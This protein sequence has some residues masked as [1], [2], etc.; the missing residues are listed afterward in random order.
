MLR[1]GVIGLGGIGRHHLTRYRQVP[2]ARVV[3]AADVR[4][5]A[6]Q[7]DRS[8]DGLFEVP[9]TEVRWF[10]DY[11]D[12]IASGSVDAVDICLPTDLHRPAAVAALEAGLHALVEKPMALIVADCDAMLAAV[13]RPGQVL[14]VAHC[15][16]FWPEYQYLVDLVRSGA[17]GRLLSLQL[18]RQGTRPGGINSG[19]MSQAARSGGAILDLHIHDVDFCQYLLGLPRGIY[20]QGGQS[21]G[22]QAGYDYVLASFDYGAGLQVSA[23]AHWVDV[24]L[25]FAARYEARL[26]KAFLRF[27]SSQEPSLTVYRDGGAEH[28]ELP[29]TDA[30]VNEIRYFCAQSLA[31]E[32]PHRCPAGEARNSVGL[33]A[34]ERA[35]IERGAPVSVAEVLG[36]A[37]G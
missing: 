13:Q 16:R 33:A 26:E 18:S 22:A 28:P 3:A 12:L 31:G 14:M 19:W 21:R 35:S 10:S 29:G 17:A 7:A 5:D 4:A 24:P 37:R 30:Y 32:A 15:I 6:L 11:R 1:V 8:L 2:E 34:G 36:P 20:A 9:P 27:D 23:A 25:P